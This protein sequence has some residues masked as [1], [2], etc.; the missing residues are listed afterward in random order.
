MTALNL[1]KFNQ[2]MNDMP[3]ATVLPICGIREIDDQ[4]MQLVECLDHLELWV[5]KGHGF[6]A[7]LDALGRLN[8]YV[9]AHFRFEEDFLKSR[10][11]PK[12]DEHIA[13]HQV[14]SDDL[15]R[16]YKHVLDGGDV[17]EALLQLVRDWVMTH[18]GIEDMQFAACYATPPN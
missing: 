17:T 14:I 18:I 11:Y 5:G 9:E 8:K 3:A 1:L 12:L 6:S 7:T 16:L 10:N 2:G 13:E 15:A 4:H